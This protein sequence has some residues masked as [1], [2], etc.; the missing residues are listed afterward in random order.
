MA[1]EY[2]FIMDDG[3]KLN[4]SVEPERPPTS[5]AGGESWAKLEHCQC[6]HCPLDPAEHPYCPA[7]LDL[8][9]TVKKV[10]QLPASGKAR[11]AVITKERAYV[12]DTSLEEGLRSLMGLIMSTSECPVLKPLRP[13][14]LQH[15]PF[16]STD[17]F[18]MRSIAFYLLRQYLLGRSGETPDWEL[19]GLV[20][21][22]QDL[23]TLNQDFWKRFQGVCKG[24]SALKALM[25][26]FSLSSSVSYS[27]ELQIQKLKRRLLGDQTPDFLKNP[28]QG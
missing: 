12:K 5:A 28:P 26:F 9:E 11:V 27:M 23:Q 10:A 20:K 22:N 19:K 4:F 8:Q 25:G 2:E 14:G 15:L 24:D 17:E 16:N 1:V 21:Q 13:M 7:A 18:I 6:S 3:Q